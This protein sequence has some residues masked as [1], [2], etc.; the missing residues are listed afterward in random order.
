MSSYFLA[1]IFC[2]PYL[3]IT[4]TL[5][6]PLLYYCLYFITA[7]TFLLPLLSYCL[8]FLTAFFPTIFPYYCPPPPFNFYP[9]FL[10]ELAWILSST[11]TLGILREI[12]SSS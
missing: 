8:Y 7:F 4:F 9:A 11:S 6:L 3:L 1:C 12:E 2:I 10:G 5:L